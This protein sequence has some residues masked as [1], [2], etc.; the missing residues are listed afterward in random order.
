MIFNKYW[1]K[2]KLPVYVTTL[3]R[4]M[5]ATFSNCSIGSGIILFDS[6]QMPIGNTIGKDTRPDAPHQIPSIISCGITFS[7][8]HDLT[9]H[10]VPAQW[11]VFCVVLLPAS[12]FSLNKENHMMQ[13]V[14]KK[15]ACHKSLHTTSWDTSFRSPT[16]RIEVMTNH[17]R[18]RIGIYPLNQCQSKC[19]N[20]LVL[21]LIHVNSQSVQSGNCLKSREFL[22]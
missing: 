4:R 2:F 20:C 17:H 13:T 1:K 9:V 5:T 21:S 11:V 10:K 7:K 14:T 19:T 12:K 3:L 16:N 8:S 18:L 22:R 6:S 15:Y